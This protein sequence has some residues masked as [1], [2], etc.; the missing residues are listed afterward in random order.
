MA[1][2]VNVVIRAAAR[3][4]AIGLRVRGSVGCALSPTY[5]DSLV[6]TDRIR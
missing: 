5:C 6:A 2:T 4:L 1:E 3:L